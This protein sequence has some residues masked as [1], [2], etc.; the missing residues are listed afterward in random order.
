[1]RDLVELAVVVGALAEPRVEDGAHGQ[2]ELPIRIGRERPPPSSPR[3][4]SRTCSPISRSWSAVRSVS[5]LAL[6]FF[7]SSSNGSSKSSALRSS[8]MRPNMATNRRQASQAKRSLPVSRI[9]P[10]DGV[11]VEAQVEDRVHHARHAEGGARAHADQQR[12]LGVAEALAGLLLER[13]HVGHDVVPQARRQLLARGVV[14][15]AGLGRDREARRDRQAR[16]R[17][18]GQAGALAA[19]ERAHRRVALGEGVDQLARS[20]RL[21][22]WRRG[23]A[24]ERSWPCGGSAPRAFTSWGAPIVAR[25]H[26]PLGA[27]SEPERRQGDDGHGEP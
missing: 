10:C 15:V 18:L 4:S 17:H 3:R 16:V 1:M 12:V 11:G 25:G 9:R 13:L 20:L 21:P 22:S 6:A 5:S 24:C 19:E 27:Q 26:A 2:L 23:G 8:T 14:G 7:L